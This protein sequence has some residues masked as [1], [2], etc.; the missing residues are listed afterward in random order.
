[1]NADR[2]RN[3]AVYHVMRREFLEIRRGILLRMLLIA[4]IMMSLLFGFV[5]TTDIKRVPVAFCDEDDSSTSR[6]L[7][8]KFLNNDLFRDEG[9]FR[10][11]SLIDGL[12]VSGKVR[13]V[14]HVPHGFADD[15]KRGR[16]SVLQVLL[17][18]SDSNAT[19]TSLSRAMAIIRGWSAEIYEK[20]MASVRTVVG[21]LPGVRM[22]E[23]VWYN[24]E[25]KSS[26]V[27]LPG[28]IGVILAMITI[29]VTAVSLVREKE[30]GSIEQ[31]N[32]TPVRP[33]EVLAGKIL[34]YVGIALVDIVTLTLVCRWVFGISVE[35]SILLLF[36]FSF[37]MILANLGIGIFIST[38]SRTQQQ[39]MLAAIIFILPTMLLSGLVF[40]IRNMPLFFQG[41]TYLIPMRYFLVIVRGIFLKGAGFAEL[42]PQALAL[43]VYS[44]V[45]FGLAVS[46]FHKKSS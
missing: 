34:P 13:L 46:R 20:R 1:M 18:G 26:V 10:D 39:A 3:T 11:P 4:P 12:L 23:R 40:A 45:I 9:V 27:M 42:W 25:L 33:W 21:S 29:I 15:V 38:I 16:E 31:L 30:S 17:D 19:M 2:I 8:E 32:V 28:L 22:E 14:F 44:A 7:R 37:L 35:G 5:A 41:L 24:P 6:Q 43:L 36:A